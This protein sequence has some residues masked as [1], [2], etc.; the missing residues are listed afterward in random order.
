MNA[1][2]P[3]HRS[4]TCIAIRVFRRDKF[5]MRRTLPQKRCVRCG[6]PTVRRRNNR[7]ICLA[8][9]VVLSELDSDKKMRRMGKLKG[10]HGRT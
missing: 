4:L 9:W 2:N 3:R 5:N 6:K 10:T 1:R 8:C 7:P